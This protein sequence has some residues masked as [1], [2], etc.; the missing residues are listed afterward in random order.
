MAD[1]ATTLNPRWDRRFYTG[2]ALAMAA[3][4]FAGFAPSFYLRGLFHG[5]PLAPLL[6]AHGL[7]FTA[8]ILLYV[9]QTTLIS[10][11]RVAIR[12]PIGASC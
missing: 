10:T 2:M 7:V 3:T 5:G 6:L 11:A 12:R 1:A 8:W 4:V 9:L